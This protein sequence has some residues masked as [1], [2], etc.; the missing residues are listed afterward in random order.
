MSR[1]SGGAGAYTGA[2]ATHLTG[3]APAFELAHAL[4]L[5]A[6]LDCDPVVEALELA[7]QIRDRFVGLL[8][9]GRELLGDGL[10]G[11]DDVGLELSGGLADCAVDAL[12]SGRGDAAWAVGA[13]ALAQ[14]VDFLAEL[15]A[16]R[17][18]A[19]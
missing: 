14:R 16:D 11:T 8:E 2:R 9:F 6:T 18:G 12:A 5:V 3:L 13:Q 4:F 10:G 1:T 19:A 17:F 7:G 15:N